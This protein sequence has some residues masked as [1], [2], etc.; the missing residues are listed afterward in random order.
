MASLALLPIFWRVKGSSRLRDVIV[1]AL[2]CGIAGSIVMLPYWSDPL[3][4]YHRTVG[5]QSGRDSPFSA[6]GY[7]HLPEWSRLGWRA[8]TA[9]TILLATLRPV[10]KNRNVVNLAA[11]SAAVLIAVQLMAIYWFYT[12]IVWFLPALFVALQS[13]WRVQGSEDTVRNGPAFEEILAKPVIP[14]PAVSTAPL[15]E[16]A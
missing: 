9:S 5:F 1:Y 6:W 11:L 10:A 8:L 14:A 2:A 13:D 7:W 15:S 3:E 16:P 12:Y 4:V